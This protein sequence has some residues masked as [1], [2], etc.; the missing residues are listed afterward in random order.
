MR[1]LR[2]NCSIFMALNNILRKVFHK[3]RLEYFEVK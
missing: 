1:V 2:L 3:V